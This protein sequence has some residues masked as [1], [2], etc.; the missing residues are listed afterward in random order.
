MIEAQVYTV[1]YLP[2]IVQ[3]CC[4]ATEEKVWRGCKLSFGT[5]PL[6][7]SLLFDWLRNWNSSVA[8]F[9]I[10]MHLFRHC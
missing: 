1:K 7:C 2:Q 9:S 5:G 3:R 10:R 8:L 6:G 4:E